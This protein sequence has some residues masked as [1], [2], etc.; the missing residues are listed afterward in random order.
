M[1]YIFVKN[2]F[3]GI[4]RT[5]G[6]VIWKLKPDFAPSAT[7]CVAEPNLYIPAWDNRVYAIQV[8]A[9]KRVFR[10]GR[11][12]SSL[13]TTE[14]RIRK[15][16]HKT[17]GGYVLGTPVLLDGFVYFG[18]EDGYL[19][20]VN[21]DGE[22]RYNVQT[23]GPIRAPLTSRGANVYVGSS[24][25]SAYAFDRLTGNNHWTY[26]TGSHVLAAI[27]PDVPAGVAFVGS[28]KNGFFGI[29]DRPTPEAGEELWH[30]PDAVSIAGVSEDFAY[31][32]LSDQRLAAVEKKKGIVQWVSLLAGIRE[33]VPTMNDWTRPDEQ[34]R[35]ICV[36]DSGHLACL[37]ESKEAVRRALKARR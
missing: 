6:E 22:D 12:N 26:P 17:T 15:I 31:F 30:I 35:L 2:T 20:A 13:T 19:Y 28:N 29:L 14:H 8:I 3:I 21:Q 9:T 10:G 37:R 23:Q 25:F 32:N 33:V 7:P 36:T 18:S 34:F 4:D 27:Y 24:D 5:R 16:W 1:V 11:A